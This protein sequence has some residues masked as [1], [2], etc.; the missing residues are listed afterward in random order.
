MST[1]D[2]KRTIRVNFADLGKK[3]EVGERVKFSDDGKQTT[4]I[5]VK[6]SNKRPAPHGLYSEYLCKVQCANGD[7]KFAWLSATDSLIR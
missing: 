5:I 7:E 3:L 1:E 6:I 4:G 2:D